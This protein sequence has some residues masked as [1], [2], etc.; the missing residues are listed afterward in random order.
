MATENKNLSEY[1]KATIPNASKFRFGIVVSEWNDNVT[2]GLYQG[3][4]HALLEN[5][6]LPHNIIRWNVPGSFELIYGAKKMQEQMV[7]AVIAIGSVIQGETK[8]FD[9]VCEGVTQGIKD[10]NVRRETPVIFCVLTDNTMQQ[11][12]DRSGGKHGN[13]GTEAA[14]AAIKMAELRKNS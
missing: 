5:G 13:K 6:V 11:A 14:I 4:Y 7:N 10:L 2:E 3:A 12:I 9:F 8:H 1:D